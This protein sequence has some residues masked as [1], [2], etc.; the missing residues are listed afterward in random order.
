MNI[1]EKIECKICG[2]ICKNIRSISGHI[3]KHN[4]NIKEYYDLYCKKYSEGI[5]LKCGSPTKFTGL[6]EKYRDYCSVK[7]AQNS[8]TTRDKS[9]QTCLDKYGSENAFQSEEIKTKYKQTCLKNHGCDWPMKSKIIYN[10]SKQTCLKNYGVLVPYKSKSIREKGK[11]TCFENH[12]VDNY[13]KTTEARQ[14]FRQILIDRIQRDFGS[15][16]PRIGNSEKIFFEQIQKQ[17]NYPIILNEWFNSYYPDGRIEEL[18]LII[19][20]DEPEHFSRGWYKEKDI[21]KN[22]DYEKWGYFVYRV[23]ETDWI[24][25]DKNEIE[26]FLKYIKELENGI[27]FRSKI[28]T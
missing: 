20:F 18:K 2:H 3:K 15:I 6:Y 14:H 23:K 4:L 16:N 27:K 19:E 9:K 28:S 21:R 24:Q 8:E 26:K 1:Q 25:N 5:C 10:K 17:I 22:L 11:H 7:C 13:S 12:G